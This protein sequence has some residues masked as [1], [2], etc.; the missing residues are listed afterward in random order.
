MGTNDQNKKQGPGNQVK[1]N[2]A[3]EGY[4]NA[5]RRVFMLWAVIVLAGFIGTHKDQADPDKINLYWAVL[6]IVGLAYMK[7]QMPFTDGVLKRIFM[8]WFWII[9]FGMIVSV[10]A[11]KT[12]ALAMLS[13]YLGVFWLVLMAAGHAITGK[14]DKK[15]V[16]VTTTGMQLLAAVCILMIPALLPLQYMVAGLV[17]ALAMVWLVLFA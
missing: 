2:A 14:I 17:G 1:Q 9:L 16:Y 7:K 11:F 15:T 10:V 3:P 5:G 6:S 8:T 4:W 12:A 13:G